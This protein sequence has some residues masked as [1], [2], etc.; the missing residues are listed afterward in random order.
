[1]SSSPTKS[2]VWNLAIA[3][4]CSLMLV[5]GLSQCSSSSST[6]S[7]LKTPPTTI[8]PDLDKV[9]VSTH[10][11]DNAR[12]GV[13]PQESTLTPIN[14]K[15]T[16]FGKQFTVTV[17]AAVYAQ[18]LIVPNITTADGQP[19]TLLIVATQNNSVYAFDADKAVTAPYWQVS[20]MQSGE[21]AVPYAATGATGVGNAIG[22]TGT[23]VVDSTKGIVYLVSK[24]VNSSGSY[25]QRLH[26]L[27]LQN[28]AEALNGPTTINASISGTATDASG[29]QISFDPLKENQRSAL[30][31]NN[32]I[33]W[34]AW[35]SHSDTLPPYHGWFLGYNSSDISKQPTVFVD[36]PNGAL[37]GIWMSAGGPGF[38]NSGNIYIVSGNGDFSA[39]GNNYSSSAMRLT[40]GVSANGG[41]TVADYFTPY[42]QASLSSV[43]ADFG[44]SG[45]LLL[46]D[47]TGPIPHLLVTSDKSSL[48]YL[49]N[50]DN[51]GKYSPQADSVVQIFQSSTQG[52]KQTFAFFNNTLYVSGDNAP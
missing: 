6:S 12:S 15:A 49:L 5:M 30:G 2:V 27:S 4:P 11:Y 38:D 50:R 35:A 17:D 7:S 24:T 46:P 51:M 37:G 20:L 29:G 42:N 25:A 8:V 39:E 44:V 28:G 33:V 31:L 10:H 32:G 36:T 45:N 22:I 13:Q 52:L 21:T 3:V 19:H 34:I 14:V 26:A 41:L 47:Q 9:G 40:P 43:D 23:P 16:T 48:V 1:M 18:P